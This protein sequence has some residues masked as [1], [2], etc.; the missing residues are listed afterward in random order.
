MIFLFIFGVTT[1]ALIWWIV[2]CYLG[3]MAANLIAIVILLMFFFAMNLIY[4][5]PT[6][7][8]LHIYNQGRKGVGYI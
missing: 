1:L 5:D 4:K 6:Q 7:Q 2:R 3:I 8:E